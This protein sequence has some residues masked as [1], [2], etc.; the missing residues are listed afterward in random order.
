MTP[1]DQHHR[2]DPEA[3]RLLQTVESTYEESLREQA[4]SDLVLKSD[5]DVARA[6]LESYE[7]CMWRSTKLRLIRAMGDLRQ[8]RATLFLASLAADRADLPIAAEAVL[9]LGATDD[10]LAGEFL[11]SIV[12]QRDHPLAREAVLALTNMAFFPCDDELEA[13]L[14]EANHGLPSAL[15]QYVVMALGI[16]GR[17]TAEPLID[18]MLR[19]DTG[20]A[21]SGMFNSALL[22][23]GRL[24]GPETLS[25]LA[26]LDTRY[27]FFAH[28][29][30]LAAVE[31]IT[32][33]LKYSVEDAVSS[34]LAAESDEGLKR[35][36]RMLA[37]FPVRQAFEAFE[38]LAPGVSPDLTAMVRTVLFDR[39][40]LDADLKFL[41]DQH[42]KISVKAFVG[43][44]RLHY[45]A[46]AA[47]KRRHV[48]ESLRYR[49]PSSL[50]LELF[51]K[52]RIP[53]AADLLMPVIEDPASPAGSPVQAVNALVA[54]CVMAGFDDELVQA[55][56]ARLLAASGKAADVG[57]KS[58]LIRA[59]GQIG[60]DAPQVIT[61]LRSAIKRTDAVGA[62]AYAAIA[63]LGTDETCQLVGRRLR[64]IA[65]SLEQADET[66]R[67]VETLAAMGRISV[68]PELADLPESLRPRLGL[69]LLKIMAENST[70][71]FASLV[72]GA[73]AT[74]DF[75]TQILGIAAARYN[76]SEIASKA[77]FRLLDSTNAC[78]SGRALDS[79]CFAGKLVDHLGL[80][81]VIDRRID[82]KAVV[83]K[84]CRGL[85]PDE[86]ADY[87]TFL[88]RLGQAVV[89]AKGA[90][91][92]RDVVVAAGNLRDNIEL[93]EQRRGGG[94]G[95]EAGLGG[96]LAGHS[97]DSELGRQ[98]VGFAG[99]SETVKSVLRNAELIH[100]HPE[101]YDDRV[102]KSTAVVQYVKSIDILLQERIG[103]RLFLAATASETLSKMQSRIVALQL[104]DETVTPEQFVT[105]LQCGNYFTS[106][107][108]PG[109]KLQS[110]IR[111]IMSGKIVREQYRVIDGLRAWAV[112][113]MA[114]GR[115][116]K[117]R[118]V[119]HEAIF[120]LKTT[121]SHSVGQLA[122][123][124]NQLQELRNLAA[125]RGTLRESNP[126]VELR[127]LCFA[128]LNEMESII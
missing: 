83:L 84:V 99:F 86:G 61:E 59:V 34:L 75:Q 63:L 92:D 40:R 53:E 120:S 90:F 21:A 65:R 14:R 1:Q 24:G 97:V 55:I 123:S 49:I 77:L 93:A 72:E 78:I 22:A 3:L 19:A 110:L 74:D 101:L 89:A 82:E 69:V 50:F 119:T 31:R 46:L 118:G 12:A 33:R 18:Q 103:S 42:Q 62:S 54:Q 113:L 7:R 98:L 107:D 29:L 16:R 108:F 95:S 11:L 28:Q 9:A 70:P 6:L 126:V 68:P 64:T 57:L 112:L 96:G 71:G 115:S 36:L 81:D 87:S 25:T 30:K 5:V 73:L 105:A 85:V 2:L 52:I 38:V 43:L 48:F 94:P 91:A 128:A 102:D 56:G 109:A 100:V 67:A 88:A 37:E 58:R 26:G 4:I 44:V 47:D 114:F 121:A 15:V 27:R 76:M 122:R 23:A 39:S 17:R 10:P 51:A 60:Y 8:E 20:R 35:S 66:V 124:L 104:D 111:A 127:G 125:H 41:G 106:D 80:L 117:Y 116:F 79:L 13:V 45:L 32:L